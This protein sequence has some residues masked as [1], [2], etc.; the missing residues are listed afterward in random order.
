MDTTIDLAR[1]LDSHR[2]WMERGEGDRAN[3]SGADLRVAKLRDAILR[4]ANLSGADLSG[5]DLRD[6]IL[7]DANLIDANLIGAD[8]IGAD[9]SG[10]DLSGADLS[11]S[12]LR[13]ADLSYAILSNALLRD[14][15]LIG[16]NLSGADLRGSDL[17]GA[18]LP[19]YQLNLRADLRVY[20]K[21]A[22]TIVHLL[23]PRN[24]RRTAS[25]VG[26][27]CRAER[28]FVLAIQGDEPVTTRGLTYR[29]REWVYPDAYDDDP[30]VECTH[31][32]H[33]FMTREEAQ[34]YA[35]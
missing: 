33:F 9:L 25:L 8:L 1:V 19:P 4:G 22:G 21:V 5:S 32:I 34:D 18:A 3:L 7:R 11:G 20:K 26:R 14:A 24:I 13:Y 12:D 2:K 27:K 28:A 23:I 17:S 16:A 6:A 30:R 31:G 15:N 10:A 29:L 35:S